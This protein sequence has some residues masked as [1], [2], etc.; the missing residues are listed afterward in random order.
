M[1]IDVVVDELVMHGLAPEQARIAAAAL[2]ARLNALAGDP[3]AISARSESAR[4]LPPV[5]VPA[6]SAAA[7]G[8]AAAGAVWRELAG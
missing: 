4:I 1:T 7:V 8:E 5:D 2:E 3:A 6:G